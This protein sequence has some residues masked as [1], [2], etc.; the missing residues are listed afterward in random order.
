MR[1]EKP[2]IPLVKKCVICHGDVQPSAANDVLCPSC[3]RKDPTLLQLPKHE[4]A[5]APTTSLRKYLAGT[6]QRG[7]YLQCDKCDFQC[8]PLSKV[9]YAH[10]GVHAAK[11]KPKEG[12]SRPTGAPKPTRRNAYECD[13]CHKRFGAKGMLARHLQR[14]EK[15][16]HA[17]AKCSATF[18]TI[19]QLKT[20][21]RRHVRVANN[22]TLIFCDQC[23]KYF[24]SKKGFAYHQRNICVRFKCYICDVT[25]EDEAAMMAHSDAK[26]SREPK[27]VDEAA[28]GAQVAD[29]VAQP[30]PTAQGVAQPAPSAQGTAQRTAR[31]QEAAR[32]ELV[33][34]AVVEASAQS[35]VS[36]KSRCTVCGKEVTATV[37][38]RHML[39]HTKE[40]PFTCAQCGKRF[41][42]KSSLQDHIMIEMGWKNYVCDICGVKFLK[43]GYLN[44]HMRYHK[45]S[46]GEFQGFECEICGKRFSEKW[47]LGVHQRSV[48]KGGRFASCKCDICG[49]LFAER[50]M[51]R[52]HKHKEHNGEELREFQCAICER[53]FLEQWMLKSHLRNTHRS[54][55]RKMYCDLCGRSDHQPQDCAHRHVL[56]LVPC[57]VSREMIRIR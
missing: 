41:K 45:L 27:A 2:F 49:Q 56:Q 6:A 9:F 24:K 7:A 54:G 35:R 50:Y 8:A 11:P 25:F 33:R 40:Q 31:A 30:A 36:A 52:V 38:S 42:R 32:E 53:K 43:Q 1:L 34:Q 22:S 14:H 17:C 12:H 18:R 21:R 16:A 13:H 29:G 39:L 46:N 10:H 37:I 15:S 4:N 55:Q 48:H 47:R 5:V 57:M 23:N 20:H 19:A 28:T 3:L 51:V 44:K 26:H